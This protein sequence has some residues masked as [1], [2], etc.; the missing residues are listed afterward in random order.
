MLSLSGSDDISLLEFCFGLD[1]DQTL[2]YFQDYLGSS[3]AVRSLARNSFEE[4]N[5]LVLRNDKSVC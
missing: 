5:L 1:D 4:S 2:S 3:K